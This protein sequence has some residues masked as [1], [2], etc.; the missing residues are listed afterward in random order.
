MFMAMVT[1]KTIL[2]SCVILNNK[3]VENI[4]PK[5]DQNYLQHIDIGML[6]DVFLVHTQDVDVLQY[7]CNSFGR[8]FQCNMISKIISFLYTDTVSLKSSANFCRAKKPVNYPI[9]FFFHCSSSN[10][11]KIY[12]IEI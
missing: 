6:H 10:R 8:F 7:C 4:I 2:N 5:P 9:K 1:I 3:C 12:I 11:L